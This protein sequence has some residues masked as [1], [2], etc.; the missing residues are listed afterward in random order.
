MN[1][2]F[3]QSNSIDSR[4]TTFSLRALEQTTI[5]NVEPWLGQTSLMQRLQ[6]GV[7]RGGLHVGR[8]EGGSRTHREDFAGF[9]ARNNDDTCLRLELDHRFVEFLLG[10]VLDYLIH[11]QDDVKTVAR[12]Q[13]LVTQRANLVPLAV[14]LNNFIT[15]LPSR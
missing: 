6:A 1:A 5:L 4:V 10:D 7:R 2:P 3:S 13:F 8:V 9:R 15:R 14:V 11:R 12:T